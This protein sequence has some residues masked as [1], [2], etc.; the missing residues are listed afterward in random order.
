LSFARKP[1]RPLLRT[2]AKA[3]AACGPGPDLPRRTAEIHS[4]FGGHM[5]AIW[6]VAVLA[7]GDC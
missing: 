2:L 1:L 3:E 6:A 7:A 4:G 5:V